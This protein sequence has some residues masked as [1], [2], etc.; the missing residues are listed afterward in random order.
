[1]P[2]SGID[3][4]TVKKIGLGFPD[5]EVSSSYGLPALKLRGSLL[6][7]LPANPSAERNSLVVRVA[8]DDRAELLAGAPEI[9]YLTDHYVNYEAVLVRMSRIGPDALRDLMGMAYKF[10]NSKAK[11]QLKRRKP[12]EKRSRRHRN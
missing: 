7:C 3:F 11:Q 9:Y 4:D 12:P 1:M 10:V 5:V 6:A 8:F 2:E